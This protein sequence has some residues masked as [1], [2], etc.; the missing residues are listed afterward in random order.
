MEY[1]LGGLAVVPTGQFKS[2]GITA[3]VSQALC[4]LPHAG[5]NQLANTLNN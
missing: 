1:G 2:R 4:P 5:Y 3:A